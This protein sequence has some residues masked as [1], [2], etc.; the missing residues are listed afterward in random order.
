MS[1]KSTLLRAIGVNAVLAEAGAPVCASS[2]RMPPCD[3]QTSI[4][5]QDSLERGV[6]YFMAALA[7]LK[8]VVD[9][10][11]REPEGRVLF[12]L[13]DEILQGTN[14]AERGIAVQAVARHLL[15][16]GAIGA[17]TTHDLNL[18]GEEPLKSA[19]RL[20]HFTEVVDQLGTMRF[21]YRLRDGLAT[22]RNALRLMQMIGI[23]V[24]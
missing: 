13:L 15:D 5:I 1:G 12:Y 19:A 3:V 24:R 9:A 10:A 22:S 11:E 8:R 7:R 2:L 18:A 17:M 21:D 6:S 4:R 23:S 14:S 20:V 16:A